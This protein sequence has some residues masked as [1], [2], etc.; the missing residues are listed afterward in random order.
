MCN[1]HRIRWRRHGDVGSAEA[2]RKHD[3]SAQE[4][5]SRYLVTHAGCWEWQ[6]AKT[7]KGYGTT[8]FMGHHIYAHRLAYETAH[9]P[10]GEG[11]LACHECDNPPCINPSHLFSGTHKDNSMDAARKGR[12]GRLQASKTHCKN[13]HPFDETNTRHWRGQRICRTCARLNMRRYAQER[14]GA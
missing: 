5:L 1:M 7:P 8:I 9:G 6:G 10:L 13:G 4:I 3:A 14:K 11:M 12:L 2:S